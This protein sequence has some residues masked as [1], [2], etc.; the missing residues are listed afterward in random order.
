MPGC[1][2]GD[3][4]VVIR[5]TRR[6]PSKLGAIVKVLDVQEHKLFGSNVITRG[7]YIEFTTKV[8]WFSWDG[9]GYDGRHILAKQGWYPDLYL[10]PI[11]PPAIM[12]G[13][14]IH[15]ELEKLV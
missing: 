4:A 14:E 6:D 15:K 10:Q 8:K 3:Q 9:N 12:R 13:E 7:C 1:K 5:G 11:R 2:V